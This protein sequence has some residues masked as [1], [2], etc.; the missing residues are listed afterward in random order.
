[1]ALTKVT[2][3]MTEGDPIN[4][5][6]FGAV[7]DGVTDD[8]AAF[9]TAISTER[10]IFLP[11]G[12]YLVTST[13]TVDNKFFYISSDNNTGKI[14]YNQAT[15]NVFSFINS[16]HE[17]QHYFNG[18]CIRLTNSNY[19]GSAIYHEGFENDPLT[20]QNNFRNIFV[21]NNCDIEGIYI[22]GTLYNSKAI[23][24]NVSYNAPPSAGLAKYLFN[25]R[26]SNNTIKNMGNAVYLETPGFGAFI[27]HIEI[28][29]NYFIYTPRVFYANAGATPLVNITEIGGT[30]FCENMIQ[31]DPDRVAVSGDLDGL[32]YASCVYLVN[33]SATEFYGNNFIDIPTIPSVTFWD[34]TVDYI[35]A[36]AVDGGNNNVTNDQQY[37]SFQFVLLDGNDD[38]STVCRANSPTNY[39]PV[40]GPVD[41]RDLSVEPRYVAKSGSQHL[42]TLLVEDR[43][44]YFPALPTYAQNYPVIW[45][46]KTDSLVGTGSSSITGM[47]LDLRTGVTTA[48]QASS[49]LANDQWTASIITSGKKQLALSCYLYSFLPAGTNAVLYIGDISSNN[50]RVALYLDNTS[51]YAQLADGV[52]TFTSSAIAART[53][54]DAIVMTYDG[55]FVY[56]TINGV[57][58]GS[59]NTNTPPTPFPHPV[60]GAADLG[61]F[62]SNNA[63][64][65]DAILNIRYAQIV[66]MQR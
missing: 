36:L 8:T 66:S 17:K 20:V 10:P 25:C 9:V 4:I 31:V 59:F 13:L 15:G 34:A 58:C 42:M 56:Y 2:Y 27:N 54:D 63:T 1:M 50:K 61:G 29:N 7:G 18:V 26:I 41:F 24:C 53:G 55:N 43:F 48:S 11:E 47:S 19:S 46:G 49:Y 14:I 40:S 62:V 21:V 3:S 65:S 57:F 38:N 28:R 32:T 64:T 6:D 52:T 33:S 51:F 23:H 35:V 45:T 5:L 39:N 30:L 16:S 12:E 60:G 37:G 44:Q 22:L